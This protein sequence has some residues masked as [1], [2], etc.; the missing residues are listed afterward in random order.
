MRYVGDRD[1]RLT[2]EGEL[3]TDALASALA[4]LS[5]GSVVTS[6]LVRCLRT[7]EKIAAATE[8]PLRADDRLREQS[9]GTWEGMSRAEVLQRSE[10]DRAT[11]TAWEGGP[12]VAPPEGESMVAVQR[13]VLALVGELEGGSGGDTVLVSHVGP[14][15]ALLAAAMR[16]RV[17]QVRRLFL[18]PAT[19]TVIDW[20]EEPLVRLCNSH[21]HIGWTNARWMKS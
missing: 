3:Q 8:A 11:L 2:E 15:K 12:G 10:E 13:R 6:P 18:D 9:F 19:I 21:A 1:E 16:L 4:Q 7:A 20:G 5:V 14:I 17:D